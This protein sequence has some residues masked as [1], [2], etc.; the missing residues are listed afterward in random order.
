MV[1]PAP[2]VYTG[3]CC[4]SKTSC[5]AHRSARSSSLH[6]DSTNR[7]CS[8]QT[9]SYGRAR[10][11]RSIKTQGTSRRRDDDDEDDDDVLARWPASLSKALKAPAMATVLMVVCRGA[12]TL[13]LSLWRQEKNCFPEKTRG[14]RNSRGFRGAGPKSKE[15]KGK[16]ALSAGVPLV[17]SGGA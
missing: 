15:R 2:R 10:S 4:T 12:C 6:L 8:S 11:D 9:T 17:S 13:I 14:I 7:F 5:L 1:L 3:S 16:Q